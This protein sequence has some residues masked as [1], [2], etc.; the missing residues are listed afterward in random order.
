LWIEEVVS[1]RDKL[2][3]HGEIPDLHP[4]M[5]LLQCKPHKVKDHQVILPQMPNTNDVATYCNETKNNLVKFIRET[6]PLLPNVA[7]SLVDLD[8]INE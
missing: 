6:I 7:F 2:I 4:M 8:K 1:W 5:V 3:H